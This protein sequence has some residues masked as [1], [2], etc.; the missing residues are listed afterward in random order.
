MCE[1]A[2]TID[3]NYLSELKDLLHMHNQSIEHFSKMNKKYL[4]ITKVVILNTIH[5]EAKFEKQITSPQTE[6][7]KKAY[8]LG[9]S[10]SLETV[11]FFKIRI[12][13]VLIK[14]ILELLVFIGWIRLKKLINKLDLFK[15]AESKFE[16]SCM[17]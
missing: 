4:P 17:A 16:E 6:E 11:P 5:S 3:K 13:Y 15:Q 10:Y 9:V 1:N 7:F 2:T 8:A 14:A 12:L